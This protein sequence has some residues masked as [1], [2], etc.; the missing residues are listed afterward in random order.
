MSYPFIDWNEV[1]KSQ[2]LRN[3][4]FTLSLDC[5][6]IWESK[7]Y[8][9]KFWDMS[10]E[11]SERINWTIEGTDVRPDSRVLDIGAGP[12]TLAIPFAKKVAHVTAIE[13]AYGMISIL[14]ERIAEQG[15]KNIAVIQ[16]S[17]EDVNADSDLQPPYDVV[18][19]SFSLGM[20]D[21][22]EAI[23]KMQ[24]ASSR[25]IYIYWFAGETSWDIRN[26]ELWYMIHGKEFQIAPKSDL[27]YC[28]LYQMGI[29]PNV[30]TFGLMHNLRFSSLKEAL[31]YLRP[32]YQVA[33]DQQES[34]LRDYL[35]SNLSNENGSLVLRNHSNR[36][37]IWWEIA[38][39]KIQVIRNLD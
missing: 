4:E 18:I 15:I 9:K 34:M 32:Q 22:K 31:D 39:N 10:Q 29:Y 3:K 27:L 30:L 19:A 23:E 1:W 33:T 21:L 28:V 36:A 11:E 35:N 7:E 12:G 25:Y 20:P 24:N 37:K 2:F 5:S 8:A 26:L 13:P 17:W 14:N 38:G 6:S 16:K